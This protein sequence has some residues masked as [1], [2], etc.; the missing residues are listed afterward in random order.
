MTD[1]A[2]KSKQFL[3]VKKL[4]WRN[5]FLNVLEL[6]MGHP[7]QSEINFL[8]LRKLYLPTRNLFLKV[9]KRFLN[10]KERSK[11]VKRVLLCRF[12]SSDLLI[13]ILTRYHWAN[14]LQG[15]M[16]K[17]KQSRH[18]VLIMFIADKILML[19]F[20]KRKQEGKQTMQY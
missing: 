19:R 10:V 2:K 5:V 20:Q 17:I 7:Y 11:R 8:L 12:R 9:K 16:I 4:M 15:I 14:L 13:T 6:K 1:G 18:V 3:T